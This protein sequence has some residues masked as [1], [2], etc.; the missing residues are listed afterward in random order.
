MSS[1]GPPNTVR[2]SEV[3]GLP[4]GHKAFDIPLPIIGTLALFDICS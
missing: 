3:Y 1:H 4:K 2:Y